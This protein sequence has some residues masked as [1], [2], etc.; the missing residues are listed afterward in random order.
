MEKKKDCIKLF[1]NAL[2][3]LIFDL[4]TVYPDDSTLKTMNIVYKMMKKIN[5]N[6]PQKKFN[7]YFASKYDKVLQEKN[8]N[9]VESLRIDMLKNTDTDVISNMIRQI[10]ENLFN[11][12]YSMSDQHKEIMWEHVGI[13]LRI[14]KICENM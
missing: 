13:L 3:D 6:L 4:I 2:K 14:N 5:R 1:N 7:E 8:D 9:I 10:Q 12:W 11:K